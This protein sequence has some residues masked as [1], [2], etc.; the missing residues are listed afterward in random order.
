MIKKIIAYQRLLL[1][2]TPSL[3]DKSAHPLKRLSF[4]V[5]ISLVMFMSI[6]IFSGDTLSSNTFMPIAIAMASVMIVN[7][8]LNADMRP[9]EIVPVSRKYT[10]I[11]VFLLAIVIVILSTLLIYISG[12]ILIWILIGIVYLVNPNSI[13]SQPQSLPVNQIIDTTKGNI[14]ILIIL[15]AI[16]FV[17]TGIAFIRNVKVMTLGYAIFAA[18]VL[19]LLLTIKNYMPVVPSTGKIDFIESFSIMPQ[20]NAIL[21]WFGIITVIISILSVIVAYKNY[22]LNVG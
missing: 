6:F 7:L 11:N 17:G 16:L 3:A 18:I 2:S 19:G 9:Y 15:I 10:V 22:S 13:N 5:L 12:I 8:I 4:I 14:F 20:S 21:I 1:N